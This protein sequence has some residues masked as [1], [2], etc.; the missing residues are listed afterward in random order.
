[1]AA[2][3]GN[4]RRG[5]LSYPNVKL[6]SY[7]LKTANRSSVKHGRQLWACKYNDKPTEFAYAWVQGTVMSVS[8]SVFSHQHIYIYNVCVVYVVY[9][10][11]V[12]PSVS[13]SHFSTSI[14][15]QLCSSD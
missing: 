15:I 14:Y 4:Q 12:T 11:Y 6:L 9:V 3:M 7:N 13:H 1:M 10:M 2:T 5:S 8:C